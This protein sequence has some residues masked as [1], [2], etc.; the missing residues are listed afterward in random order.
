MSTTSDTTHRALVTTKPIRVRRIAL[1]SMVVLVAALLTLALALSNGS[2]HEQTSPSKF[3]QTGP[4][5]PIPPSPEER[6]QPQ[7][8][9]G[10]GMRP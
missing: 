2:G 8:L 9:N 1:A 10:P 4:A 3:G 5:A 6:H 7:G